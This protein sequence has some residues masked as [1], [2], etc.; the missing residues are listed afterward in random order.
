MEALILMLRLVVLKWYEKRIEMVNTQS[1]V[2][3]CYYKTVIH[4]C[5][6]CDSSYLTTPHTT[7][8]HTTPHR[9]TAL[10]TVLQCT[11][12]HHV[13]FIMCLSS[14]LLSLFL[15]YCLALHHVRSHPITPCPTLSHP[16]ASHCTV[17]SAVTHYPLHIT[18]S[19]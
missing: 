10:C 11:A 19:Y 12:L 14:H 15:A 16:V 3:M 5:L 2:S 6:S 1:R 8:H 17:L 18:S 13:D 4:F 9:T 7:Q